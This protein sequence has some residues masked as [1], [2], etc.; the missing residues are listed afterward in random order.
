MEHPCRL[1]TGQ[2]RSTSQVWRAWDYW[3]VWSF[4]YKNSWTTATAAAATTTQIATALCNT[5]HGG[6]GGGGGEGE[7]CMPQK[8]NRDQINRPWKSRR[9]KTFRGVRRCA[10]P[11]KLLNLWSSN[12]WKC[13]GII[14][15]TVTNDVTLYHFKSLSIPSDGLFWLLGMGRGGGGC[16]PRAP[17]ATP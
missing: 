10:T 13:I 8:L 7:G 5:Y 12:C 2:R 1:C 6:G 17:R 11:E 16:A 3:L 9:H 4:I 15:P 14:N